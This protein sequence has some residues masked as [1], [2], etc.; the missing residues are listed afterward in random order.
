MMAGLVRCGSIL[1]AIVL[2]CTAGAE[3]PAAA[4]GA[5]IPFDD[6]HWDLSGAE[7]V[8]HLGRTALTG[9]AVLKDFSF[10]N[11]VI[12]VDLAAPRARCYPGVFFRAQADSL[13]NFERFYVRPHR[14]GF[15]PDAAQYAPVFNGTG[16][17]QLYSGEGYTAPV[18]LPQ[19]EWVHLRL[20]AMGSQA[21]VYIGDMS[22]PVL[23]IPELKHGTSGGA[24]GVLDD[25]RG[26]AYFSN[27][28][29]RA[30]ETLDFP[31]APARPT[32]PGTLMHWE[33]SRPFPATAANRELYPRFY[34]IFGALWQ[35]ATPE[36]DGLVNVSR[37]I[38]RTPQSGNCVLGRSIVRSDARQGV[39]LS[40]WYSDDI[41]LFHNGRAV[42]SGRN[43]Y[44][45]RDPAYVGTVSLNDAAHITLE[46][47]LNEIL[48]YL[49]D[50][51]GGW[52]FR[53]QADRELA[54][55]IRD[56]ARL[57][58]LWATEPVFLTPETVLY[59]PQRQVF[60]VTNFDNLYER[61]S[62]P[63]GFISRIGLD[64]KILDLNWVIKL[65]APCGLALHGNR[66]YT[67]ERE[68]LTEIDADSG[69]ILA[70]YPIAAARFVNDVAVDAAGTV[71]ISD[72]SPPDPATSAIY[73]LRDGQIETWLQG[74]E[75]NRA[76]GLWIHD[77]E[78]LIGNTGDGFLLAA[79]LETGCVRRITCLGAGVLDGIRVDRQGNY[80]VSHWEGQ[81][82]VVSPAG[83]VVEILDTLPLGENSADFE[84]VAQ[85]QL[86][87]IPT[88]VANRVVAYRLEE[89]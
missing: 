73:R 20:E 11:G 43:G 29:C 66:L 42:Y 88:F 19:D 86:L 49:S 44:R 26:V 36:A 18:T 63:S 78:L 46:K 14:A 84:Y 30:D 27:F 68:C 40:L 21:R 34:A 67:A 25:V 6:A 12:E 9:A 70:R 58:R 1:I 24:V 80:L 15:Y 50:E 8:E 87:V 16:C 52:G 55:P 89:G 59:D 82:Y 39:R 17:W 48:F 75:L 33:V 41:D 37:L 65:H 38:P 47:G 60:Y 31:P 79:D 51:S 3:E 81:V 4:P 35:P 69:E 54:E 77:H 83:D 56:P 62:L 74:K 45:S 64:G 71:Y 76:N 85:Q 10:T 13:G 7:V 53:F 72:T 2:G 57:T 23:V 32:P 5:I 61:R 28:S 22:R